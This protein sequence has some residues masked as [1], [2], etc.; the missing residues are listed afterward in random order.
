MCEYLK[1]FDIKLHLT[2]M[3]PSIIKTLKRMDDG[4]K[5]D[6]TKI[7]PTI[8]DAVQTILTDEPEKQ[9]HEAPIYE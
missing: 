1:K 3:K 6:M 2:C 7:Y 4:N 5:L 8:E 9:H